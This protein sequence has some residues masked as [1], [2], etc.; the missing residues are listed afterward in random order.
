MKC[1]FSAILFFSVLSLA[2][3][4]GRPQG[5]K[6]EFQLQADLEDLWTLFVR[7]S[8]L[9]LQS[10]AALCPPGQSPAKAYEAQKVAK[11]SSPQ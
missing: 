4:C 7:D 2:T 5:P 8:K 1:T 3:L 6:R 10:H 9:Y 11:N